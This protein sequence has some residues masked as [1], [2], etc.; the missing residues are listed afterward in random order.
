MS[1]SKKPVTKLKCVNMRI[2]IGNSPVKDVMPHHATCDRPWPHAAI[3]A[4]L[5]TGTHAAMK[6]I[7]H[8]HSS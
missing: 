3:P 2:V 6:S 1:A 8:T 4:L 5:D 7:Q